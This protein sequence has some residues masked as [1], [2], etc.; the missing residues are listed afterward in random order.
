MPSGGTA[1]ISIRATTGSESTSSAAET[2]QEREGAVCAQDRVEAD[3]VGVAHPGQ[4]VRDVRLHDRHQ[5]H[6]GG[7]A[8]AAESR[9]TQ[10]NTQ[11]SAG[12]YR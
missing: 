5:Y 3:P 2:D 11:L 12:V 10:L 6:Q 1:G 9:S 7:T 8:A 4:A